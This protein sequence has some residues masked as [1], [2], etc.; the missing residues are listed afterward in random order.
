M[1]AISSAV[2]PS[3]SLMETSIEEPSPL[4]LLVQRNFLKIQGFETEETIILFPR[5]L[6]VLKIMTSERS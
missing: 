6:P 4:L 3:D 2:L 5:M 1:S